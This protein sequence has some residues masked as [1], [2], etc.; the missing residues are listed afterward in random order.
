MAQAKKKLKMPL[1][2]PTIYKPMILI[3]FAL[4]IQHFSGFTFTKKFLL[5][6]LKAQKYKYENQYSF[7]NG[8][9]AVSEKIILDEQ[10]YIAAMILNFIR[11][12]SNLLMAKL[13]RSFPIRHLY[14]VSLFSTAICL[15]CLGLL[16]EDKI[17]TPYFSPPT[18]QYLTFVVLGVHVFCVQFGV[19]TLAGTLT[20]IMLPSSSRPI[21]KGVIRALQALTLVLFVTIIKQFDL[22]W[23]F[24]VMASGLV[25]LGPIL[26]F[27]LPDIRNKELK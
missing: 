1:S 7:S 4:C 20:D 27:C 11:F 14:L 23:S 17:L 9:V 13:L 22:H 19:Q 25:L 18:V 16:K 5:Q 24:W 6:V 3:I 15:T 2:C 10:S 12:I 8:S 21:M 26:Y